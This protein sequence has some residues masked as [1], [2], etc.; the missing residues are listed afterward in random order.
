MINFLRRVLLYLGYTSI[1]F[2]SF[3]RLV[4]L[5]DTSHKARSQAIRFGIFCA[6]RKMLKLRTKSAAPLKIYF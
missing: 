5:A 2:L 1:D 4:I 6:D 3:G